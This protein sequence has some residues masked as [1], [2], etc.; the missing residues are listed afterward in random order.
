LPA[1]GPTSAEG[2]RR[3][4][5]HGRSFVILSSCFFY[6]RSKCGVKRPPS[7]G[8]L[9]GE[10]G[11]LKKASRLSRTLRGR[12]GKTSHRSVTGHPTRKH[13]RRE[14]GSREETCRRVLRLLVY[15]FLQPTPGI[16]SRHPSNW[17]ERTARQEQRKRNETTAGRFQV[18]DDSSCGTVL[19][20]G[21][22]TGGKLPRGYLVA[23]E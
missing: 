13:P 14:K 6:R 18:R 2:L 19:A 8:W 3:K 23:A 15:R 1:R 16:N 11:W 9:S 5:K 21:W 12:S 20:G 4:R 10:L 17:K 22:R 7:F